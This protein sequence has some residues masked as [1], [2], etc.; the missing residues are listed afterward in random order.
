MLRQIRRNILKHRLKRNDI[1]MAWTQVQIK[2]FGS[3]AAY[4]AML[5]EKRPRRKYHKGRG[6]RR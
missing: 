6:R 3:E 5:N 1:G 2:K 4:Y